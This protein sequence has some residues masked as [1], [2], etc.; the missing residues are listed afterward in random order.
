M[1]LRV[2]AWAAGGRHQDRPHTIKTEDA[3]N[4]KIYNTDELQE[5]GR[6]GQVRAHATT[7]SCGAG[8]ATLPT[9]DYNFE[10]LAC[11]NPSSDS[12]WCDQRYTE[13]TK[14]ALTE[15]DFKKRVDLLHQAER[16]ELAASPYIIYDFGP[17]LSVTRTDTWT[18][19][20]PSPGSRRPAVR[21][22]L[23]P[24]PAAQ[25]G[26]EGEH[27][28]RR[29]DLGDRL[30]GRG[31]RRS[32]SSVGYIRR[33]RE[34]RQPFELPAPTGRPGGGAPVKL[35]HPRRSWFAIGTL[36]FVLIFNFF[37]FR[38]AGN[39]KNDLI[40]GNPR[41]SEAGRERLIKERGLDKGYVDA[42]PDLRRRRRSTATSARASRPTSRSRR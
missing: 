15:P 41:L 14:Q 4:A 16:I 26:R 32:S 13:L 6:R 37:L 40:R 9:P 7:R 28:L 3:L 39:P 5:A 30:P 10:V 42:V 35:R 22:E 20:R 31:R 25:P 18:N 17:Y 24:A 11:G 27:E 12:M 33:R 23:D 29:H 21:R 2:K 8:S 36:V 34:E 1:G 38:I 19:W